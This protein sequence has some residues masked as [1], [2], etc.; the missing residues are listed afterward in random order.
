MAFGATLRAAGENS[1]DNSE[2]KLEIVERVWGAGLCRACMAMTA[3]DSVNY[4]T[5]CFAW[6]LLPR[7][8]PCMCRH[9]LT[10]NHSKWADASFWGKRPHISGI[11]LPQTTRQWVINSASWT[12]TARLRCIDALNALWRSISITIAISLWHRTSSFNHF[13]RH[14]CPLSS[15]V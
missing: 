11:Y 3:S 4:S 2:G 14:T 7:V 5:A 6:S 9:C 15:Q 12:P 10:I 8:C 13:T 1:I